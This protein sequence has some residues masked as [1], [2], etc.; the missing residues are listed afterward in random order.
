LTGQHSLSSS[1]LLSSTDFFVTSKVED[2]GIGKNA[3]GVLGFSI[4]S[5][6]AI[7]ALKDLAPSGNGEVLLYESVNTK[8]WTKVLF[9]YVD[10]ARLREN[11]YTIAEPTMHSESLVINV[12]RGQDG[13]GTLFTS[14]SNG[15]YFVESLGNTN[16]NELGYMV[17]ENLYAVDGVWMTNVVA[18]AME[19]EGRDAVKQLKSLITF[20]HGW[21]PI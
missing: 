7:V 20:D 8:D 13:I 19:V 4:I 21:N 17:F 6:F 18:N 5:K 14:N 11:E 2:L 1:R 9:P 3:K 12:M 15:T 10:S 16:R